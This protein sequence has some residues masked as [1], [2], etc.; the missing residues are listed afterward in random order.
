LTFGNNI[1]ATENS[2]INL[3]T[4]AFSASFGNISVDSG[5]TLTSTGGGLTGGLKITGSIGG[6]GTLR[7]TTNHT[8][9]FTT[10]GA[11]SSG[12]PN[13]S[14]APAG[15]V[16]FN[17]GSGNTFGGA[18]VAAISSD[19]LIHAASGI[20]DLS[21]AT[22]TSPNPGGSIVTAGMSGVTGRFYNTGLT[23]NQGFTTGRTDPAVNGWTV[24]G[25][26]AAMDAALGPLTAAF[27]VPI[28]TPLNFPGDINNLTDGG[29][30]DDPGNIFAPSGIGVDVGPAQTTNFAVRFAGKLNVAQAGA[31]SFE[32]L[33]NDGAVMFVDL[34]TGSG[35]NW[36]MVADNNRFAGAD[37]DVD[38]SIRGTGN[39]GTPPIAQIPAPNLAVGQYDFMVASSTLPT[40]AWMGFRLETI[41]QD[42]KSTGRRPAGREALSRLH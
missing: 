39:L 3:G 19:G 2:T 33:S 7:A 11:A 17:P 42:W 25:S 36:A 6:S 15:T 24:F 37:G 16:R 18:S 23:F 20:T 1:L 41:R 12:A 35:V 5:K 34:D 14:I 26:V 4:S 10:N 22:V 8:I 27:N 28:N 29:T 21:G 32:V 9:E 38:S 31:T 30:D 13:L 40:T